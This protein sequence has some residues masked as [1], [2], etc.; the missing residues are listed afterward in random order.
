M[1]KKNVKKY[2]YFYLL[3]QKEAVIFCRPLLLATILF[4]LLLT[5]PLSVARAADIEIPLPNGESLSLQKICIGAGGDL[6]SGRRFTLGDPVGGYK[7]SSTAVTLGGAFPTKDGKDW[8]YYMG[9]T[10]ITTGQYQSILNQNKKKEKAKDKTLK[11]PVRD[12]TWYDAGHFIDKLNQ[13]IYA[14]QLAALPRYTKGGYGYFRLPTEEEWEFAARG[15]SAV[16]IDKF[17]SPIPFPATKVTKYEWFSGPKSSHN[18]VRPVG[19]LKGN[20]LGLHDMLGNVSEMTMSLYR[21]EYYQGRIGGF[22]ARGG[23]YL[24]DR[25]HLR[26]SARSEQPFYRWNEKT[27]TMIPNHQQTMGFRVVLSTIIY[28]ERSVAEKMES[29]WEQYRKTTGSTTP[30]AVSIAP[31]DVQVGVQ[32]DDAGIHI[33]R[34]KKKFTGMGNSGEEMLREIAFIEG[35]IM[36]TRQIRAKAEADSAAAWVLIA[37][38]RAL[39]IRRQSLRNLKLYVNLLEQAQKMG[40]YSK[41]GMYK[42]RIQEVEKNIDSGLK[43]YSTTM[44]QLVKL[45]QK[46]V[47]KA[48]AERKEYLAKENAQ[49]QLLLLPIIATHAETYRRDQRAAPE[50]WEKDLTK[51]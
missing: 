2:C 48:F 9:T 30:A 35:S 28:P 4:T 42:V 19:V 18:K 45:E 13:W 44:R 17:D 40:N 32:F 29:A 24:T 34:L 43:G 27:G 33:N 47:E 10:E 37:D 50:K 7:E 14:N 11:M 41:I 31:T 21:V 3:K 25:K 46:A 15:G 8:C 16:S 20:P 5:T 39:M 36:K 38:E 12:I 26:S 49:E 23:H 22:V 51:K 6:F 1:N